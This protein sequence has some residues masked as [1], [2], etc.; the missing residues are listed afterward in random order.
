MFQAYEWREEIIYFPDLK[1]ANSTH[2]GY[3]QRAWLTAT[4]EWWDRAS[5][6]HASHCG[7]NQ[8]YEQNLHHNQVNY[9]AE[10]PLPLYI[11]CIYTDNIVILQFMFQS[12]AP[13]QQ[14][15]VQKS[16]KELHTFYICMLQLQAIVQ[17]DWVNLHKQVPNTC[18]LSV[19]TNSCGFWLFILN[20]INLHTISNISLLWFMNSLLICSLK[21]AFYLVNTKF[22][23]FTLMSHWLTFHWVRERI[24]LC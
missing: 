2:V 14:N 16:N 18:H 9:L 1:I 7:W 15:F 21:L 3:L 6:I 13:V 10:S 20:M 24:G 12:C 22:Q 5:S 17:L 4:C 11:L 19:K 23:K 8:A